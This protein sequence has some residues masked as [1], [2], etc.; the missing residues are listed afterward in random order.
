MGD[1]GFTHAA[2][3]VGGVRAETIGDGDHAERL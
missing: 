3:G 2:H 1:A